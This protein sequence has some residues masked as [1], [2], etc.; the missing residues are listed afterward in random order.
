[1]PTEQGYIRHF[2]HCRSGS[3]EDCM[4]KTSRVLDMEVSDW[5]GGFANKVA[6]ARKLILGL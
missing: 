6:K 3:Y 5:T 2:R 1:M 4:T